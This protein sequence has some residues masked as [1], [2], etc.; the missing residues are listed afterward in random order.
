MSSREIY[1][2]QRA[3]AV[4][5]EAVFFLSWYIPVGRFIFKEVPKD[6][7]PLR[8]LMGKSCAWSCVST[9][10]T[11]CVLL[12]RTSARLHFLFPI[13]VLSMETNTGARRCCLLNKAAAY[14]T[15]FVCVRWGSHSGHVCSSAHC[16]EKTYFIES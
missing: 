14:L 7:N 15:P 2:F 8:K 11:C 16:H 1:H 12:Q 9:A 4:R 13:S 3:V 10:G 6:L 5:S